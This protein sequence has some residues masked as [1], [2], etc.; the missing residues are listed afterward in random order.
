MHSC[1]W[2]EEVK[3]TDRFT[4]L[5]QK[6]YFTEIEDDNKFDLIYFDAFGPDVQPDLWTE[7]IFAKMFKAL[8]VNGVLVTYSSKGIVK[9]ALRNVGFTVKRLDGPAGKRHMVRAVK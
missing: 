4:L 8:K 2:E 3:I 9:R 6:K 7:D 5:K 1:K